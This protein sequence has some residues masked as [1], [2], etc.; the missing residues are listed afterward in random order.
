MHPSTDRSVGHGR[1]R[2]ALRARWT[3][4]FAAALVLTG[5][6]VRP[7]P[8]R[9]DDAPSPRAS[10]ELLV[11]AADFGGTQIPVR[12]DPATGRTDFGVFDGSAGTLHPVGEA[13]PPPAGDYSLHAVEF[14]GDQAAMVRLDRRTGKAWLATGAG[15]A[16]RP[17]LAGVLSHEN[18]D[19][20]S[21]PGMATWQELTEP[22]AA[23]DPPAASSGG[24][25]VYFLRMRGRPSEGFMLRGRSDDGRAWILSGNAWHAIAEANPP[26]EGPFDMALFL[27][28]K[29]QPIAVRW[30][31]RTGQFWAAPKETWNAIPEGEDGKGAPPGAASPGGSFTWVGIRSRG[32]LSDAR[33]DVRSGRFWLYT[34]HWTPFTEEG[35]PPSPSEYVVRVLPGTA[36]RDPIPVRLDVRTGAAW[37]AAQG[38]QWSVLEPARASEAAPSDATSPRFD[39]LVASGGKSARIVWFD[40]WTGETHMIGDDGKY[41]PVQ[42]SGVLAPG[43]YDIAAEVSGEGVAFVVRL[44]RRRGGWWREVA[45]KWE[46]IRDVPEAPDGAAGSRFAQQLLPTQGYAVAT[47]LDRST[48]DVLF[49]APEGANLLAWAARRYVEAAAPPP[50]DYVARTVVF[51]GLG[52]GRFTGSARLDRASGRVWI[53]AL[54]G[55]TAGEAKETWIEMR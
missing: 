6:G 19:P 18:R 35:P 39:L 21:E 33:Y 42:D 50:G 30:C 20:N 11:P 53:D 9:A 12:F 7:S 45:G 16:G 23:A 46:R 24:A 32:N 8:C 41:A 3:L 27:P 13:T 14:Q 2:A 29:G 38:P 17:D 55:K 28:A 47:R 34:D 10:W 26:G 52:R 40:R 25:P 54:L 4:G 43:A 31:T 37:I 15:H 49:W 36:D 48:G 22:T 5:V 44:D 1:R 51:G